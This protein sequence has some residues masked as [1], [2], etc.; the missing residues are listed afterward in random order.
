M[1]NKDK[2]T[3]LSKSGFEDFTKDGIV[4][5]DFFAEWCMPCLMMDPLMDELSE[6]FK[7]K[8]KFGKVNVDD[9]SELAG[10]FN[11]S[12]IPNFVLLKNGK[13]IEQFVGSMSSEEFE[14][15]LNK[16]IK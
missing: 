15:K 11:V 1:G 10:K 3:E 12:S 16:F 4:L 7:G 14:E 8:I 6:K 2:I 9:N 5:I 13:E